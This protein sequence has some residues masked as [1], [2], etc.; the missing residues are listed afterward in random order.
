VEV[1]GDLPVLARLTALETRLWVPFSWR[2]EWRAEAS[3]P[4]AWPGAKNGLWKEMGFSKKLSLR[5]D[6][7]NRLGRNQVE[8]GLGTDWSNRGL[9]TWSV[10]YDVHMKYGQGE[11][12]AIHWLKLSKEF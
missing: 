2:D 5:S 9:G 12:E 1:K 8:A 7:S 11:S 6:Y 10:D 4:L 3:L